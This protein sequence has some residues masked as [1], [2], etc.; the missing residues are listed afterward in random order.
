MVSA[1]TRRLPSTTIELTAALP[2]AVC[3]STAPDPTPDT[4]ARSKPATT[5]PRLT[6]THIFIRKAPLLLPWPPPRRI[7]LSL[8]QFTSLASGNSLR[9]DSARSVLTPWKEPLFG[10]ASG[11]CQMNDVIKSCKYHQHQDNRQT[12]A[13]AHFLG[14]FRERAASNPFNKIEQK[15]TAIEQRD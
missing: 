15:V 4:K 8:P 10:V 2:G 7:A 13:E 6:Q 9:S 11:R 5:S 3:A 1:S 14:L 12:D